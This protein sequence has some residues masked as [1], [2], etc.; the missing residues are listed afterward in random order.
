MDNQALLSDFEAWHIILNNGLISETKEED[1]EL[2]KCFQ[3]LHADEQKKYMYK[4]WER[5]FDITPFDNHW[6]RRG[7]IGYKQQLGNSGRKASKLFFFSKQEKA[8]YKSK[9]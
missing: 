3:S 6:I 7:G 8:D 1:M 9:P 5:V 4:N 2:E